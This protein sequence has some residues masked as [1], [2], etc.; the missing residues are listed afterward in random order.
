MSFK[1]SF[2]IFTCSNLQC[3][4]TFLYCPNTVLD[5]CVLDAIFIVPRTTGHSYLWALTVAYWMGT[6]AEIIT[7]LLDEAVNE[8]KIQISIT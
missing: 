7:Q 3:E 4:G 6:P 8:Q 5:L 1:S 2:Y